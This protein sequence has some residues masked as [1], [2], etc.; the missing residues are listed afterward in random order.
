MNDI[1]K[2]LGDTDIYCECKPEDQDIDNYDEGMYGC[3]TCGKDL[4]QTEPVY[5]E[6]E[7]RK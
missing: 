7:E 5:D 2:A 4:G 1:K 3:N 6:E